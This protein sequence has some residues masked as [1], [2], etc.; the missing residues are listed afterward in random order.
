MIKP[1]IKSFIKPF[2]EIIESNS[3]Y[4]IAQTWNIKFNPKLG[5]LITTKYNNI[6]IFGIITSI[7]TGSQ[8]PMRYPFTYQKTEAELLQ[9]QP[10][11]FEFIKT[12]IEVHTVG[13]KDLS[14]KDLSC[15][16]SSCK[17]SSIKNNFIHYQLPQTPPKIH[18]F[19]Q[20][21]DLTLTQ[22]FLSNTDYLNLLFNSQITNIDEVLLAILKNI[23]RHNNNINK[24]FINKFAHDFSILSGNDYKRLKV[25]LKRVQQI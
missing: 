23:K 20:N 19:V 18:S 7:K 16:D 24:D 21:V 25:F 2:G 4:F 14:C 5:Q 22:I 9:E 3:S 10:Q 6:Q 15:K 1:L 11:I 8:D 12:N 17:D 13:Y